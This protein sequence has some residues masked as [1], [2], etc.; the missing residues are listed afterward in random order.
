MDIFQVVKGLVF[1]LR[2]PLL[3]PLQTWILRCI[4]YHYATTRITKNSQKHTN[5]L[6]TLTRS[7]ILASHLLSIDDSSNKNHTNWPVELEC[8]KTLRNVQRLWLNMSNKSLLISHENRI[9]KEKYIEIGYCLINVEYLLQRIYKYHYI[10]D[11]T[12]TNAKILKSGRY[13]K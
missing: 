6:L 2:T 1:N 9:W 13:Q 12:S 11:F 4:Q 10:K 8:C 3:L 7:S 5:L